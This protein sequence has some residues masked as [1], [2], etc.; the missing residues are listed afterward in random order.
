MSKWQEW[1]SLSELWEGISK[2]SE[3]VLIT[4]MTVRDWVRRALEGWKVG[5][6]GR[7]GHSGERRGC[8]ERWV[9]WITGAGMLSVQYCRG[10]ESLPGHTYLVSL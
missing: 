3:R 8:P 10:K 5:K 1:A 7:R 4:V 2:E 9:G 6:V